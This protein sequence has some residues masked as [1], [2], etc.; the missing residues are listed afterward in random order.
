MLSNTYFTQ[1]GVWSTDQPLMRKKGKK[2]VVK[3]LCKPFSVTYYTIYTN[4]F[5]S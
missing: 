2:P 4:R 1:E 3:S 5:H